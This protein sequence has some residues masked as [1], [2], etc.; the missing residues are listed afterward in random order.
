MNGIRVLGK[1]DHRLGE[2]VAEKPHMKRRNQRE[3]RVVIRDTVGKDD[4]IGAAPYVR[5][6]SLSLG[7]SEVEKRANI[8]KKHIMETNLQAVEKAQ[9]PLLELT[10]G[11]HN[12][13]RHLVPLKV[14]TNQ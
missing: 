13:I 7:E 1:S 12:L 6:S 8:S 11:Q 9:N 4:G 5:V 2:L 10:Y 14:V 3:R